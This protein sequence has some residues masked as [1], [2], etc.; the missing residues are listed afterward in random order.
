MSV[1]AKPDVVANLAEQLSALRPHPAPPSQVVIH[2]AAG[3]TLN[4]VVTPPKP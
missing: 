3:A 4:L 2:L 1:T